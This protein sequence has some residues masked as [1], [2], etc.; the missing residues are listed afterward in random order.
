MARKIV[1]H[2]LK[3]S[4]FGSLIAAY[5]AATSLYG[6]I[7]GEDARSQT[8][9]DFVALIGANLGDVVE[10]TTVDEDEAKRQALLK[11]KA[12][13]EAELAKLGG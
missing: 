13:I 4:E 6:L 3:A 10:T 7:E 5:N 9:K 2:Q 12:E 8:I 1:R 11:K